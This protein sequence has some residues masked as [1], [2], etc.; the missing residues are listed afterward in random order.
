M[1]SILHTQSSKIYA[2]SGKD[3]SLYAWIFPLAIK[4]KCF[5]FRPLLLLSE[6]GES[7]GGTTE[8]ILLQCAAKNQ[9]HIYL[10]IILIPFSHKRQILISNYSTDAIQ[11]LII[12]LKRLSAASIEYK[13]CS[14]GVAYHLT[15]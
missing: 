5:Y 12:L 15:G 2:A 13:T 11:R 10:N 9:Y 7:Q 8:H 1:I 3:F 4:L 6:G 14:E